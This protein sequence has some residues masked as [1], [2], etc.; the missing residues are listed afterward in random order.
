MTHSKNAIFRYSKTNFL[1]IFLKIDD[2][3]KE[4]FE[5]ESFEIIERFVHLLAS[6]CE[7]LHRLMKK[8]LIITNL[9]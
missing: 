2:T 9:L 6:T 7:F 3:T 4:V 1:N 5:K 8:T